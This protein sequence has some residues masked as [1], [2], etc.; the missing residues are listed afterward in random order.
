MQAQP[1]LRRRSKSEQRTGM[2]ANGPR[3]PRRAFFTL[4]FLGTVLV[5]L[6]G[7]TI[8][9]PG[10]PRV[11]PGQAISPN[12]QTRTGD[13]IALTIRATNDSRNFDF[14]GASQVR[15]F[16][17]LPAGVELVDFTS[18]DRLKPDPNQQNQTWVERIDLENRVVIVSFN[19][20]GPTEIKTAT[21]RLRVT[22]PSGTGLTFRTMLAWSN[23]APDTMECDVECAAQ[24]LTMATAD[25][26]QLS[27]YIEENPEEVRALIMTYQGGGQAVANTVEL[28]VGD[29]PIN[30]TFPTTA[31]L[32]SA[33]LTGTELTAKAMFA[34]SEPVMLWYNL[35][36][37]EPVFLFRTD[38][39][40]DGSVICGMSAENWAAIPQGAT[41]IVARGQFSNVEA[42]YLFNR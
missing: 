42:V 40:E 31:L 30:V 33:H 39:L 25:D 38:A 1:Q 12:V 3:A 36:G 32:A 29:T 24:G 20:I 6:T 27:A 7:C 28:A 22:A 37:Q 23:S 17:A 41:S 15:T 4:L 21:L 5:A 34:P 26:P 14:G 13:L 9:T 8:G 11:W 2:L 18:S 35:P 16:T 10:L 19:G